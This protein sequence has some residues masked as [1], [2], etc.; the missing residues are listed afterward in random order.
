MKYYNLDLLKETTQNNVEEL[1][2][3]LREMLEMLKDLAPQFNKAYEERDYLQIKKIAHNYKS[4][5]ILMGATELKKQLENI[6]KK[7]DNPAEEFEW[8]QKI[9]ETLQL[10]A[11]LKIQLAAELN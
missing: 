3:F 4:S 2:E 1:N 9:H 8:Q 7:N 11:Q 5:A 6:E 10:V